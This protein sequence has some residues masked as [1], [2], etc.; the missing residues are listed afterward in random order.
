MY[1]SATL[2]L[3]THFLIFNSGL[4][5]Q[6]QRRGPPAVDT[7]ITGAKTPAVHGESVPALVSNYTTWDV[8]D[9]QLFYTLFYVLCCCFSFLMQTNTAA[10]VVEILSLLV[11]M[12]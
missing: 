11:N 4:L 8:A 12:I 1:P 9:T 3:I 6:Q 7:S 10:R 5:Q 2:A